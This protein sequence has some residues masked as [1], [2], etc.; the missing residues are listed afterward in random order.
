MLVIETRAPS[1]MCKCSTIELYPVCLFLVKHENFEKRILLNLVFL[2]LQLFWD[3]KNYTH[4][5][6]F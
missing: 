1:M 4:L 5:S 6:P 2:S 3:R